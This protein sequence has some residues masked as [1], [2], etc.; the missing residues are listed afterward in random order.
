MSN[1]ETKLHN[2]DQVDKFSRIF[3][4]LSNPNRLKILLQLT[5]CSVSEGHFSTQ[6]GLE[7]VENCQHE[8]AKSLGLAPS[9]ISHHFKELR[10]AGFLKMKR[11][12]K[13]LIVW[14]DS[15]VISSIRDLF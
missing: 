13:N 8:F 5:H 3:K 12:G 11:E 2:D 9:T 7:Q 10:Q 15:D 6:I 4:A 1:S 14:V